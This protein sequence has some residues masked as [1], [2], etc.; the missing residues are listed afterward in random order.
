MKEIFSD[1]CKAL[2]RLQEA[3]QQDISLGS[4]VVD[5]TIQ[6]FEFCF[7][8][9]WKLMKAVLDV[10]NIEVPSPRMTIKAAYQNK[11]IRDGEAWLEMLEDRNKTA[12][13]YDEK[14]AV[15][16]YNRIKAKY[17][18]LFCGFKGIVEKSKA[19]E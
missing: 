16:I 18:Q 15:E 12:H 8:L 4:I 13:I 10:D 17:Y 11:L 19:V 9:A 3:L 6:R 1:Y 5:G 14:M 2:G 7:E